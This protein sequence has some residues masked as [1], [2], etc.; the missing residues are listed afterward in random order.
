MTF[1]AHADVYND[2]C[3]KYLLKKAL[4]GV[5][6]NIGEKIKNRRKELGFTML[7]LAGM[8][9]VSEGTVSRWESG[10]IAN[11]RRDK[12]VSLARALCVSPSFIMEQDCSAS[13]IE[14]HNFDTYAL[15]NERGRA[16]VDS[17]IEGLLENP[18]YRKSVPDIGH[19]SVSLE[20]G[21]LKIVAF[22][23]IGDTDTD[24]YSDDTN[25]D[26]DDDTYKF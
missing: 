21:E 11:M 8:V 14:N 16:K 23:G 7:E 20:D 18:S 12:I 15:L 13:G 10:Y 6:M 24:D 25:D 19:T 3:K 22:G 2:V 1:F 26:S 9:G 17:Y 4:R 5:E